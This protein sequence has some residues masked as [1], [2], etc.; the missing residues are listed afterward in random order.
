MRLIHRSSKSSSDAN[1][2]LD[3]ADD[4]AEHDETTA[5]K[6]GIRAVAGGLRQSA[7]TENARAETLG[8]DDGRQTWK[9]GPGGAA[10]LTDAKESTQN[11]FRLKMVRPGKET[12]GGGGGPR[13]MVAA[14]GKPGAGALRA[15][16]PAPETTAG[17]Q[18]VKGASSTIAWCKTSAENKNTRL[19]RGQ[20][21]GELSDMSQKYGTTLDTTLAISA[22]FPRIRH[23]VRDTWTTKITPTKIIFLQNAF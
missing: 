14:V 2:A 13:D 18:T 19:D 7:E 22:I 6:S 17:E 11:L 16:Q 12:E 23:S 5:L 3:L 15:T 9:P 10:G 20:D 21:N 4:G 1:L 8:P